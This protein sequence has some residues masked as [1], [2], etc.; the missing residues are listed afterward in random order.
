M[1]IG[2]QSFPLKSANGREAVPADPRNEAAI[3]SA[4]RREPRFAIVTRTTRG[5]RIRDDYP[6]AGFPSAVDAAALTCARW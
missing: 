4:M 6:L 5:A 1:L 3:L 2:G